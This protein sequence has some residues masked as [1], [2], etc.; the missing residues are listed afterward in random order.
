M[1]NSKSKSGQEESSLAS[2]SIVGAGTVITGNIETSGDL[3][4]DGTLKGN[5]ISKGKLLIGPG[6]IV[7]GD[8]YCRLADILGQINGNIDVKDLLQLKGK[9]FVN[10]DITTAKLFIEETASFNGQCKMGASVVE[11]KQEPVAYAVNE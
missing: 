7:E 5:I 8:I 1:F 2:S 6:G 3:R 10:G 11:L 4:I 9:A